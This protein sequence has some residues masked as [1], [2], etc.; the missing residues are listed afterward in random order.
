ML[1]VS[2]PLFVLNPLIEYSF[3]VGDVFVGVTPEPVTPAILNLLFDD[4]LFWNRYPYKITFGCHTDID[5]AVNW[6]ENFFSEKDPRRFRF[7]SSLHQLIKEKERWRS[8][9]CN[10]VLYLTEHD[11]VML[12]KLALS[13]HITKIESAVTFDQFRKADDE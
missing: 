7:G 2:E 3:F 9:W 11:D 10:P 5:K 13:G 8:Y 12:C 6:F 1:T 4:K